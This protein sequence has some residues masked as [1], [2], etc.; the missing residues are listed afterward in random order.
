MNM[1]IIFLEQLFTKVLTAGLFD[2]FDVVVFHEAKTEHVGSDPAES[3]HNRLF[4]DVAQLTRQRELTSARESSSLDQESLTSDLRP[5]EPNRYSRLRDALPENSVNFLI[6]KG[7]SNNRIINFNLVEHVG[8]FIDSIP[9]RNYP[10]D[11]ADRPL[12]VPNARLHRV[13]ADKL[14]D[15]WLVK[16]DQF[17]RDTVVSNLARNQVLLCDLN[18]LSHTVAINIDDLHTI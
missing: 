9:V 10:A 4:H 14:P 6:S 13:S 2:N 8:L 11:G 7:F 16:F 3:R 17:V 1:Q 5:S 15:F 12:Q 18:F